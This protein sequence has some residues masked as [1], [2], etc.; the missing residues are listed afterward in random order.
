V[1][2][3]IKGINVSEPRIADKENLENE[4]DRLVFLLTDAITDMVTDFANNHAKENNFEEKS[5]REIY[6]VLYNSVLNF[7]GRMMALLSDR[8]AEKEDRDYF[9]KHAKENLASSIDISRILKHKGQ[10]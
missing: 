8:M 6:S 7:T 9:I 10:H 3:S 5:T 2:T 4:H 1:L